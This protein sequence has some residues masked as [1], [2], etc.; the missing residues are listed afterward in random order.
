MEKSFNGKNKINKSKIFH[1]T[2]LALLIVA[3]GSFEH[4]LMDGYKISY[5]GTQLVRSRGCALI[6]SGYKPGPRIIPVCSD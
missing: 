2:H 1:K 3:R 4:M 5:R 6:I